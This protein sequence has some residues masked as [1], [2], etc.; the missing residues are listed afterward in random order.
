MHK[1]IVELVGIASSKAEISM[2]VQQIVKDVGEF[3][4]SHKCGAPS[5]PTPSLDRLDMS[6]LLIG[7]F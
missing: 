7:V 2:V 6:K 1:L 3:T 4:K 5:K